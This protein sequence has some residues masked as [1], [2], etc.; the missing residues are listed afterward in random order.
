MAFLGGVILLLIAM[1]IA[2]N[3]HPEGPALVVL[4]FWACPALFGG[5]VMMIGQNSKPP[6]RIGG[7]LILLLGIWL[8]SLLFKLL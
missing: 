7:A 3:M 1:T 2:A 8:I 4:L 5:L 6:A